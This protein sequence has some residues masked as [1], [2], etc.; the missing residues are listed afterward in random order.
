MSIRP[1]SPHRFSPEAEMHSRGRDCAVHSWDSWDMVIL[2]RRGDTATHPPDMELGTAGGT[3]Q[4]GAG[5]VGSETCR[6]EKSPW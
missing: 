5:Q 2:P 1:T 3:A 4:Q 6:E